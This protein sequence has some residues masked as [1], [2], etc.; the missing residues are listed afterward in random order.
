MSASTDIQRVGFYGYTPVARDPDVLFKDHP[1]SSGANP[2]QDAFKFD[3]LPL[4]DSPL[5]RTVKEFV[6]VRFGPMKRA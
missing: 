4:P 6:K 2:K 5:V 3:D 1:T